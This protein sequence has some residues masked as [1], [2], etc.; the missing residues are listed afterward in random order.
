M[1]QWDSDRGLTRA[2]FLRVT[3]AAA[4]MLAFPAAASA[5]GGKL[6]GSE[7][8]GAVST[9]GRAFESFRSRPDLRPPIVT[10]I[11]GA[12]SG[13]AAAQAVAGEGYSFL[14]PQRGGGCQAGLMI[15]DS[16]GELVW[17]RALPRGRWA[18]SFA[19]QRYR[20]ERVL[21]WWEG[22]LRNPPGYGHGEGVIVDSSY[23]EVARVR[24]GRGRS[25]DLHEIVLTPEGTAL[26]TCYPATVQK[27]LSVVGGAG[28]GSVLESIIQEIDV[29]TGRVLLEWRSLDHIGLAES[30]TR[31]SM[32][33]CMPTRSRSCPMATCSCRRVIPGRCTS[34]SVAAVA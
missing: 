34:C 31:R 26:I 13:G 14:A 18:T 33:R 22:K 15:V 11:A 28:Q 16:S 12:G 9:A 8:S 1:L 4:G 19:V 6:A 2:Q 5:A 25:A 24:A 30:Y 3:G 10:R 23:R 7:A 20:G 29:A 32:T 27:D 17:F 21:T